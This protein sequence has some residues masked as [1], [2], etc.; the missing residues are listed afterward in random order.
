[1]TT[2]MSMADAAAPEAASNG[3][4]AAGR[5][6]LPGSAGECRA[7]SEAIDHI[8]VL[9]GGGR[10]APESADGAEGSVSGA[11]DEVGVGGQ[12]RVGIHGCAEVDVEQWCSAG[13]EPNGVTR[14]GA[15]VHAI[16]GIDEG[17][18]PNLRLRGLVGGGLGSITCSKD[19]PRS[20]VI[21]HIRQAGVGD[22]R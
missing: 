13:V 17:R 3:T 1:L 15:K 7:F 4:P 5:M 8:R 18:A 16:V 14:L 20:A 10:G 2:E 6:N 22:R 9:V 11:D 21:G 19:M 12:C